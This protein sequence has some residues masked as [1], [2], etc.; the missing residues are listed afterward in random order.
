MKLLTR[1]IDMIRE[2]CEKT[3]VRSLFA[4]GSVIRNEL[5]AHSDVDFIV[6]FENSDP[7]SYS[8]NYFDLK[9][10]LEDLLKRKIDLLE[11]KA[12]KNQYLK[13]NIDSH[14]VLVYGKGN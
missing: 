4:F 2:L 14:K 7:I 5:S 11:S 6:D 3:H 12:I 10:H 1:N 13:Q 9:F 8:D